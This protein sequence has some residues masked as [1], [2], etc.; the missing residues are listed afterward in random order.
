MY[1]WIR[2]RVQEN[3]S[4]KEHFQWRNA[5]ALQAIVACHVRYDEI[6]WHEFT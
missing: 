4:E 2:L 5:C 6:N 3:V 1:Q